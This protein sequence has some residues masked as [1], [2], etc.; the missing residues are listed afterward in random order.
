MVKDYKQLLLFDIPETE[1]DYNISLVGV[2]DFSNEVYLQNL[3]N[4]QKKFSYPLFSEEIIIFEWD[5]EVEY[6]VDKKKY[7]YYADARS[8]FYW[9]SLEDSYPETIIE[10][11]ILGFLIHKIYLDDLI[12]IETK[13]EVLENF[14]EFEQNGFLYFLEDNLLKRKNI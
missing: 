12:E 9:E 11:K 14:V 3:I 13:K 7:L 10:L 5:F 8:D 6:I 2:V 1:I 4:W